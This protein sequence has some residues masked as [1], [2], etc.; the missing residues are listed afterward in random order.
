MLHSEKHTQKECE[1]K[2]QAAII[3]TASSASGTFRIEST[4][5][6]PGTCEG[7]KS[8]TR[9]IVATFTHPGFINYVFVSNYELADPGTLEPEPKDC[10]HWYKERQEKNIK[11]CTDFPWINEDKLEGPFHTN[12]AA[13]ISG[14]PVFG[15]PGHNDAVEMDGGYYGGT[16]KIEGKGYTEAGP[17]LLPP[18]TDAELVEA[19]GLKKTGR[20]VIVLKEGTPNTMEITNKGE[21]TTVP[22]PANGVV[23]VQNGPKG[24]GVK[25][26]APLIPLSHYTAAVDGECGNVYIKGKYTESLTVV[27]GNDL[28]MTG[29]LTTTGGE[30]GAAPTGVATLGLIADNYVRLYHP[31]KEKCGFSKCEDKESFGGLYTCN[32]EDAEAA[33]KP[34]FGLG[35]KNPII[36]AAILSTKHSWGVDN[37]GCGKSLGE[38]IIWGTIAEDW[39][40]RVT[41]CAAGGDYLKNYKYDT[42]LA[43]NQPPSFLAPSTT[44]AWKVERETAPPEK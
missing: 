2:K 29:N 1:E 19:A 15:R 9:S 27:A 18:E 36:D 14:T 11:D 4:G 34:E 44:G 35:L 24:C 8:C 43:T 3:E 7:G 6:S 42:R 17:I 23:S 20:T 21:T 28:I 26:F 37:F 40:G 22:F 31:V 38:I 33:E 5:I 41:C 25:Y 12:D 30:A 13:D 16:P 10:E 32:D 39:R